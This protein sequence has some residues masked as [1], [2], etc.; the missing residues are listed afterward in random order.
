MILAFGMSEAE[1]SGCYWIR[2]N[3]LYI[4][5]SSDFLARGD[6]LPLIGLEP[7]DLYSLLSGAE[8]SIGL[9]ATREQRIDGHWYYIP[10]H[11]ID[12]G[13]MTL[14]FMVLDRDKETD[15]DLVL[16]LRSHSIRLD[17]GSWRLGRMQI[18][19][20]EAYVLDDQL[21]KI[22]RMRFHFE[23]QR[24][25]GLCSPERSR[26]AAADSAYRNENRLHH[27]RTRIFRYF[28]TPVLAGREAKLFVDDA[29]TD[30][31]AAFALAK[32][33]LHEL[34]ALGR[35]VDQLEGVVGFDELRHEFGK[36]IARLGQ[37]RLSFT[38]VEKNGEKSRQVSVNAPAL[39]SDP[40]WKQ[41]IADAVIEPIPNHWLLP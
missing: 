32:Q 41:F 15:D 35:E 40:E 5:K 7:G 17:G 37:M 30:A 6:Y 1:E 23:L 28:E 12:K 36:L 4:E 22:N 11:L 18:E 31:E 19:V 33:N 38:L 10:A 2:L 27:L 9:S 8:E 25:P 3:G 29:T 24:R 26:G 16:P 14:K 13:A 34:L 21:A 39:A 20:P